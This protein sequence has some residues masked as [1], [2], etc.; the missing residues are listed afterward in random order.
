MIPATLLL[1]ALAHTVDD[2]PPAP[3]PAVAAP[4]DAPA[5][6]AAPDAGAATSVPAQ[7]PT[8]S[9]TPAPNEPAL[10]APAP[11]EPAL[12]APAPT[13]SPPAEPAS[14]ASPPAE[15]AP[16]PGFPPPSPES[17]GVVVTPGAPPA[18]SSPGFFDGGEPGGYLVWYGAEYAALAVVGGVY[19]SGVLADVKPLPASVGPQFDPDRPDVAVLFDP[20]LDDVV[21]APLVK[22]KVPTSL[23]VAG[24]ALTVLGTA[25]VDWAADGDVHRTHALVL[26]G[27]EAIVGT[28]VVTEALKLGLGRL[29][30]DFRDRW[31]RAACAG[32]VEAPPGLDCSAVAADGFVV[33]R[34]DVLDGMKS[35]PSGHTSTAFATLSFASM[36][37]G[38]RWLWGEAAAKAPAWTQPVAGL[39][40]GG[41]AAATAFTAASRVG[42]GRHHP[43]DVAVGAAVGAALGVTSWL[44]HFDVAGRARTRWPVSVAPMSG[45]GATGTGQGLAVQGVF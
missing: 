11:N 10:T 2:E 17:R 20:R 3:P 16:T 25:A 32:N 35:F 44:V 36:A 13:A 8:S 18:P 19:A 37:I 23:V 24:A 6:P 42:D 15:P 12:T 29:R 45:V 1:V 9:T 26:G 40:L 30:P 4:Q 28:F 22:E 5:A 14:T 33:S 34:R 41:L 7:P 39:T 43:E 21:G 27:A 31:Q 38:S